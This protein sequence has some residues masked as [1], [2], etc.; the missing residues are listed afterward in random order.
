M[1]NSFHV[2]GPW[3]AK[4]HYP[5]DFNF[6]VGIMRIQVSEENHKV[7]TGGYTWERSDMYVGLEP[8][9]ET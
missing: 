5:Y 6:I 9:S 3:Y 2:A 7:L 8:A 4:E 1:G